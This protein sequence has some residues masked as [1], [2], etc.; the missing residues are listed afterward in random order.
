[1]PIT[2][3][4]PTIEE[5]LDAGEALVTQPLPLPAEVPP[6]PDYGS[7]VLVVAVLV[8]IVFMLIR[9]MMTILPYVLSIV[10]GIA[11]L[12]YFVL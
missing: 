1:M 7:E 4:L 5:T 8:T 9:A 10:V 3:A 12:K 2:L 11:L 6:M